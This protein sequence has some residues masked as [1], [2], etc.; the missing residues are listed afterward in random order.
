[1]NIKPG[2]SVMKQVEVIYEKDTKLEY[3]SFFRIM[4]PPDRIRAGLSEGNFIFLSPSV[5]S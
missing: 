2:A 3:F 4:T 5:S 1:V